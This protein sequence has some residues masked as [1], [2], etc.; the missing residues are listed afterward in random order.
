VDIGDHYQVYFSLFAFIGR[1]E[2]RSNT[3][4]N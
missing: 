3:H 1:H 4:M 2:Q